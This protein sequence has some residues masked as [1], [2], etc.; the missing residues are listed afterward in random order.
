MYDL[1]LGK[2]VM[3]EVEVSDVQFGR[4][5]SEPGKVVEGASEQG[6]SVFDPCN[7]K[8]ENLDISKLETYFKNGKAVKAW[9]GKIRKWLPE[10]EDGE[11]ETATKEIP[12]GY[13]EYLEAR[14]ARPSSPRV[15]AKKVLLDKVQIPWAVLGNSKISLANISDSARVAGL[16]VSVA[17]KSYD[18]PASVS[19]TFDFAAAES[20]HMVTG[21]FEGLD[22]S[23]LQNSFSSSAG[24][25]FEKG[26]ASG[27]FAGMITSE[28]VDLTADVAIGAMKAAAGGEG[29]W[30]LDSKTASEAL[31]V[32]ENLSVK[33][34][35]VGPLSE[36]RLAFDVGVLQEELKAA[37]VKAGKARLAAEV[38]KQIEK[39]LGDKVPGGIGEVL[40]KPGDLLKG[41][42]GLL[43]GDKKEEEK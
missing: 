29:L 37:L 30:G 12:E 18:T 13:L 22:L 1:L 35:I 40:K 2:L 34:R 27:Q 17:V 42:G 6:T 38:D 5:R 39:K 3:E 28:S 43:D 11:A 4:A 24:L 21:S 14:A 10:A 26:T 41:L 19:M 36:P 25:V 16:P 8:L 23:T 31:A 15:L 9:L 33:M 7:L 32:M 20:E